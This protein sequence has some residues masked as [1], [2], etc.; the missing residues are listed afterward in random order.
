MST[1]SHTRATITRNQIPSSSPDETS[2]QEIPKK[3]SPQELLQKMRSLK[4]S[5]ETS[6]LLNTVIKLRKLILDTAL[7]YSLKLMET[8]K[9]DTKGMNK[10]QKQVVAL[11]EL[12]EIL[13][14][15]S[16]TSEESIDSLFNKAVALLEEKKS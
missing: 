4:P 6:E 16:N 11:G 13:D 10:Y 15:K 2:N 5:G 9:I 8:K 7:N 12:A 14:P 3:L 1:I